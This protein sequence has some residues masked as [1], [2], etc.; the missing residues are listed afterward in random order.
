MGHPEFSFRRSLPLH[1]G[2]KL[3]FSVEEFR[4][5]GRDRSFEKVSHPGAVVILPVDEE[6]RIL[7]VRQY[8]FAVDRLL[9]ELPAGTLERSD[10]DPGACAVRELAEEV[11]RGA[12]RWVP[13]GTLF[14]APGFCDEVQYC[15]FAGDL[16]VDE[17]KA[18]EDEFIEVVPMSVDQVEAAIATGELVDAKS[19]GC[20]CRARLA[21]LV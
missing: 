11:G 13:L 7:F 8:R 12:K 3:R 21:R 5:G 18:D 15:F 17:A 16:Y 9:L 6:G 20:F 10:L 14:P 19:I 2:E 1:E 4:V